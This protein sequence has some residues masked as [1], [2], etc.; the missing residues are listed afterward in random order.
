MPVFAVDEREIGNKREACAPRAHVHE[1]GRRN[2]RILPQSDPSIERWFGL[3]PLVTAK[4]LCLGGDCPQRVI[5]TKRLSR[6]FN[7]LRLEHVVLI[8]KEE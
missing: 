6:A 3:N 5:V 4:E 7:E 1:H 2:D 8:Y